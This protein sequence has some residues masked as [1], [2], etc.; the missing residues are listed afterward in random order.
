MA[1]A[2]TAPAARSHRVGGGGRL[3]TLAAR[4]VDGCLYADLDAAQ[5]TG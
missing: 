5:R 4:D 3:R 2:R 1:I